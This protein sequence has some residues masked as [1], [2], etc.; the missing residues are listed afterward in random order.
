MFNLE[1]CGSLALVGSEDALADFVRH[2]SLELSASPFADAPTV[3][4]VSSSD[5][6]GADFARKLGYGDCITNTANA[7]ALSACK[8]GSSK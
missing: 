8:A 2:L 7:R 5:A 1:C 6:S 4:I 3:L